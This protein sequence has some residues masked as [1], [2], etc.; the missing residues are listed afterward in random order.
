MIW[1]GPEKQK[2]TQCTEEELER[3]EKRAK[4]TDK[5]WLQS[6]DGRLII[7][8]NAQ[9]KSL[10]KALEL[11]NYVT[12]LSAFQQTLMELRKVT[13]DPASESS[14]PLS[15]PGTEVLI[16]VLTGPVIWGPIP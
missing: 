7:P 2:K 9:W 3:Y 10:P 16:K 11:T 14:T 15:E 8:E 13:P 5:G 6:E 12:R 4:I 1:T